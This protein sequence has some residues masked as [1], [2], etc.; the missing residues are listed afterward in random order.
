MTTQ[1][2]QTTLSQSDWING[3]KLS[4]FILAQSKSDWIN[5]RKQKG[6]QPIDPY[7]GACKSLVWYSRL[8]L[9]RPEHE[10]SHPNSRISSTGKD[11]VHRSS[12]ERDRST[13]YLSRIPN[14][15]NGGKNSRECIWIHTDI[16]QRS[17]IRIRRT[18]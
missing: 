15:S 13:I 5:G 17:I 9:T 3:R 18:N 11:S 1:Y 6:I 4:I 10:N 14:D 16:H 7:L 12:S 2:F 8:T